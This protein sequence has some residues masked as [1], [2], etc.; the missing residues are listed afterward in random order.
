MTKQLTMRPLSGLI[1]M[2]R[3]LRKSANHKVSEL[4]LQLVK[5][6]LLYNKF[7]QDKKAVLQEAGVNPKSIDL[8]LFLTLVESL[9]KRGRAQGD[10]PTEALGVTVQKKETSQSQDKNWDRSEKYI[11]SK[12][13]QYKIWR[14]A[15][16]ELDKVKSSFAQTENTFETRGVGVI[17]TDLLNSEIGKLFFPNQPLVSPQLIEK[18]KL[19][20]TKR[21]RL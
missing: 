7:A 1:S 19:M 6:D 14:D 3:P 2:S 16:T 4:A 9:R 20:L 17:S 12:E 10:E 21:G 13:G 18:L 5:D 8:N 15:G 11:F